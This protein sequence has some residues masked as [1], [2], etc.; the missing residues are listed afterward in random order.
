MIFRFGYLNRQ[1]QTKKESLEA[2]FLFDSIPP[3]ETLYI[4]SALRE[5]TLLI[6]SQGACIL[7]TG[8]RCPPAYRKAPVCGDRSLPV[9]HLLSKFCRLI[10]TTLCIHNCSDAR[11]IF[12]FA[13]LE[14]VLPRARILAKHRGHAQ[15]WLFCLSKT[16]I[17][18]GSSCAYLTKHPAILQAPDQIKFTVH[19]HSFKR[20]LSPYPQRNGIV[21]PV[22][23]TLPISSF[24]PQ[25]IPQRVV[26]GFSTSSIAEQTPVSAAS[27]VVSVER[28]IL[29]SKSRLLRSACPGATSNS[30]DQKSSSSIS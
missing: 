15:T 17:Y 19:S 2:A 22:A 16:F 26:F 21:I 5:I 28:I 3:E 18:S 25:K 27:V 4:L 7:R 6:A 24:S 11:K 30:A 29:L 23:P 12:A 1:L 8:M 14:P 13:S 20:F 10:K 9:R